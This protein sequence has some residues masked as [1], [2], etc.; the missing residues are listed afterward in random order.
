MLNLVSDVQQNKPLVLNREFL[1][2]VKSILC[3]TSL[4]KVCI[5]SMT[6]L[7]GGEEVIFLIFRFT[8]LCYSGIY[9]KGNNSAR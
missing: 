8:L 5:K 3:D 2:G 6:W 9:C 4:D 1:N 7:Q